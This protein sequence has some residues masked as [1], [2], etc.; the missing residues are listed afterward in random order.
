MY[1]YNQYYSLNFSVQKFVEILCRALSILV[2]KLAVSPGAVNWRGLPVYSRAGQ[3]ELSLAHEIIPAHQV[4]IIHLQR[5]LFSP[6]K[7]T[8][9]RDL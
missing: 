8:V 1:L 2:K 7:G 6:F 3:L 5:T 9:A 4:S